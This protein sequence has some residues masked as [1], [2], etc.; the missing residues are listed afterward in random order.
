VAEKILASSH[1]HGV[2]AR[3]VLAMIACESNFEEGAVSRAG[4]QGLGQLMPATAEALGVEDA[5][6][7][8][9]NLDAATRLLRHHLETLAAAN[10]RSRPTTKDLHLALACYNAGPGAIRRHGGVPPYRETNHYI[11]KITRLYYRFSARG[12]LPGPR[13]G[14]GLPALGRPGASR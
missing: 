11:R 4:A 8:D 1:R 13:P 10:R 7:P 6:D 9:A 14:G 5:F 12:G 2:D 3:L